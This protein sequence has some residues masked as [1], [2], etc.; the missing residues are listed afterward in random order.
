MK[1][2]VIQ[3]V[4]LFDQFRDSIM[5]VDP[6]YFCEKNLIVDGEPMSLSTKG[7]K[8][9]SD[10]YR[11]IGLKAINPDAKPIVLVKGRQVGATTMAAAL[12]CYFA[13]CGVFGK[14]GRPPMRLIH[15]FPTLT[16][17]AA[18]TKDKLDSIIS[19]SKPIP[20]TMK[21]NGLPKSFMETKFDISNPAN[22]NMS[23]KRFMYGNQVWIDSTGMDGDRIRGRQLSLDTELPTPTGFIKL[24]DLKEGDELFDEKGDI[25]KV[26]KLHPINLTPEAYKVTFDDGTVVEACSEHLWLTEVEGVSSVKNT[27][28]ILSSLTKKHTIKC[29]DAVKYK[30]TDN[31][32]NIPKIGK[33]I[34]KNIKDIGEFNIPD[35]I[36]YSSKRGAFLNEITLSMQKFWGKLDKFNTTLYI[37]GEKTSRQIKQLICSLGGKAKIEDQNGSYSIN[38]NYPWNTGGGLLITSINPIESIPMRCITVNSPSHLYLITRS[39]IPTHN[40]VDGAMFDECFPYDQ[41]ILTE[42]GYV[43]IGEL[44]NFFVKKEVPLVKTYNI[45]SDTF[46]FKKI[47][48]AWNRGKKPLVKLILASGFE[49]KCTPNHKFLTMENEWVE[50]KDLTNRTIKCLSTFSYM[51]PER[52]RKK[53]SDDIT[54]QNVSAVEKTESEDVYDIEVEDN[55]N[56][57]A[58]YGAYG[59]GLIA[60]NCQDIPDIAMGAVEKILARSH[61]GAVGKGVQVY[62]GTPKRKGGTYWKMWQSSSQN[63]FHLRCEKCGKYFPLYRPDINWEDIW[64]YGHTVRCP[65][66]GCEQDKIEAQDRGKWIPLNPDPNVKFVGYHI[67]QLY[68]PKFTKE[69]I[70]SSKPENSV[71]NTERLYMN[72]VLGEF[73]DGEGGTITMQEI[74]DKCVDKKR[75]MLKSIGRNS[76]KRVY[77]GFDWGQR[78]ALEQVAGKGRGQSY[79]CFVVLTVEDNLFNVQFATK[80]NRN[81]PEYKMQTV[82]EVF[83]RYGVHLAVGDIGDAN[84]LTHNL[85]KIYDEKFLASRASHKVMGHVK[86]SNEEWP[87]TIIFEKDYYISEIIGLLKEGRIKFPLYKSYERISWLMEHCASMDIKVTTDKSGEPIRRFVKGSTPNDGLMALLNAYLAWK[88]D[89]T[90]GF[91]ISNP[92][93]MKLDLA[94]KG[95]EVQAVLGYIPGMR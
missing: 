10:I 82:E 53:K 20:G 1:G 23:F 36:L 43:K 64:L 15:L 91:N 74:F 42:N 63:Y 30:K 70:A 49:V 75:P 79:S 72:E 55:H 25:C 35:F 32:L 60:H 68:I 44:F 4:P 9:F 54:Q 34:G 18:Y 16:L 80:L 52:K 14:N 37:E 11:Y 29:C 22:N 26:T 31:F 50:A 48:N 76:N 17:A 6:V 21:S 73:H 69:V 87:K 51:K 83:R 41:E 67:N 86:Y 40:T 2:K 3:E 24:A 46:E 39:F 45:E 33:E 57:I 88:F 38:T 85:Q 27:F 84:D 78:S 61:Y 89:V 71:L 94:K 8:P 47:K 12:T 59:G 65:E 7:F 66:C 58:Y 92:N 28:E 77:V 19:Q 90:Q 62:F 93:H 81:E 56:F 13:A 5:G 95:S